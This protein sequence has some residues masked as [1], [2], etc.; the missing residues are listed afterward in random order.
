MKTINVEKIMEEIREEIKE[1]GYTSD[2][3]S[4]RDIETC[5][6]KYDEFAQSEYDS[7]VHNMGV[8]SYVPW[9]RD[10]SQSKMK[11]II[12]KVIRKFSAFLIAPISDQQS[13]FN[14]EATRAFKQIA[15]YIE[16][17]ETLLESQ[18]KTVELLEERIE[19]LETE[20]EIL[21]KKID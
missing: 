12:Q 16:Q 11:R 9:Y 8:Y 4:F 10:L 15:G 5:D 14:Y 6:V 18:K 2:M 13:D 3:L 17:T 21:R 7:A 1:K 20:I 19:K